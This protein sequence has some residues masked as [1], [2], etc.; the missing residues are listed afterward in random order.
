MSRY[1]Y[2]FT[3]YVYVSIA[4]IATVLMLALL[5]VPSV[6][7]G[8]ETI[9]VSSQAELDSAMAS[10]SDDS[11]ITLAPGVYPSLEISNYTGDHNLTITSAVETDWAII[12]D[13]FVQNAR[14]ITFERLTFRNIDFDTNVPYRSRQIGPHYVIVTVDDVANVSFANNKFVG[15]LSSHSDFSGYGLGY[16]LRTQGTVQDLELTHNL[17][18]QLNKGVDVRGDVS[19]FAATENEFVDYRQDAFYFHDKADGVEISGNTFVGIYPYTI[20]DESDDDHADVVQT[21]LGIDSATIADNF[22]TTGDGSVTQGFFLKGDGQNLLVENNLLYTNMWHGGVS[23]YAHEGTIRHN[24]VLHNTYYETAYPDGDGND[25]RLQGG[26]GLAALSNNVAEYYYAYNPAGTSNVDI[27]YGDYDQYFVDAT[28]NN[29]ATIDSFALTSANPF[30]S[31]AVTPGV[32]LARLKAATREAGIRPATAET[33][34]PEESPTDTYERYIAMLL[35]MAMPINAGDIVAT[36]N[37]FADGHA[38]DNLFDGC[39]TTDEGCTIG[40]RNSSQVYVTVDLD[41][42]HNMQGVLLRGDTT[43]SWHSRT[44]TV[45]VS[46]DLASWEYAGSVSVFGDQW[47]ALPVDATGRYVRLTI[48]G[49]EAN[50]SVQA[51]EAALIGQ[52][53][54]GSD[55]A[56]EEPASTDDNDP[57]TEPDP[58][59]T[60]D[61]EPTPE[62]NPAELTLSSFTTTY[63]IENNETNG[64]YVLAVASGCSDLGV[65]HLPSRVLP[66]DSGYS[67]PLGLWR[68]QFSCDPGEQ[69]ELHVFLDDRYDTS[70]WEY[71]FHNETADTYREMSEATFSV[72]ERDGQDVTV[73]SFEVTEGGTYDY[74]GGANGYM[75]FVSGPAVQ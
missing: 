44:L 14:N 56:D 31:A 29:E 12:G 17:F 50:G 73:I 54:G 65:K 68:T 34:D 26:D 24:T 13:L 74:K 36:S 23:P 28:A 52:P 9:S 11:V 1:L 67:Y 49:T 6:S 72:G 15:E 59:P 43:G 7:H 8:Q 60:S 10:I 47:F 69:S 39:I 4:A 35:D 46:D 53:V 71:R 30:N 40:S 70:D 32:D 20:A 16:G 25:P 33:A 57:V 62:P 22:I 21:R 27:A 63:D 45:S 51:L 41:Q 75:S 3:S 55:G 66:D 2:N 18:T 61:P 42:V 19:N 58:E 64:T 5:G 37:N 38:A 48:T